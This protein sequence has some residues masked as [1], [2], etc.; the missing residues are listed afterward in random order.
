VLSNNHVFAH[1]NQAQPG[2]DL[3]QPGP[4][5]GGTA[6][7]HF[8]ELTRYVTI[9]LNGNANRVDAAIGELIVNA[10]R[11][12]EI[13]TIGRL[14]GTGQATEGMLVCKHGRTTGYTEGTIS[15]ESYDAE[16][17]M[18]TAGYALFKDQMRI[19]ANPGTAFALGGDSGSLIVET[20]TKRAVGLFFAGPDSGEY[21]L[22]NPLAQ[23]LTE[24]EIE[25]I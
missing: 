19:E 16:V 18:G 11:T 5:D 20:A 1:V 4:A 25:L 10:N 22:A 21:G 24:L 14:A 6:A 8:A 9:Q 13:C 2:D 23:V 3:Y 12:R 17:D 7:N 15:D